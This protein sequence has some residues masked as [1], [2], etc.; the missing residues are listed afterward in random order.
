MY[1]FVA[2]LQPLDAYVAYGFI[3]NNSVIEL[4]H[5]RAYTNVT[6]KRT[7]LSDNLIVEKVLGDKGILCLN[8]LSNEIFS[9][10]PLFDD[11]VAVIAPFKLSSPVGHF[12]KKI[13]NVNDAVESKGGFIGDEMEVF[14]HKIL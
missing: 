10:G 8:D 6:G 7:P 5:R 4:V 11:C 14:L 1:T 3:S 12:E 2:I 9:I 13:L